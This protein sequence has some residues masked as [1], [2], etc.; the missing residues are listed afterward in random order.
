MTLRQK[1]F[2]RLKQNYNGDPAI[3]FELGRTGQ[4]TIRAKAALSIAGIDDPYEKKV[5]MLPPKIGAGYNYLGGGVR[6]AIFCTYG[7][8]EH[9][10]TEKDAN[11]LDALAEACMDMVE[12][13]EN[14]SGMND[15]TDENGEPNWDAMATNSARRSGTISAY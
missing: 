15:E 1:F 8:M 13:L 5:T 2:K 12:W 4:F 7:F 10:F 3:S 11:R 9:G 6:G 14:Q